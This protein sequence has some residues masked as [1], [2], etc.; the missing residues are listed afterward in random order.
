MKTDR[1]LLFESG[2]VTAECIVPS[3]KLPEGTVLSSSVGYPVIIP[4]QTHSLN[5]GIIDGHTKYYPDTDALISFRSGVAIG[6]RTADCV[7]ILLYFTS[8]AGVAAI[9]AGWRGTLGGIVGRVMDIL[10]EHGVS[11]EKVRAIFGPSIS[12]RKYEVDEELAGRFIEAGFPARVTRPD[13]PGGKPHLDLQ[14]INADRLLSRGVL[15][16]NIRLNPDC[17]YSALTPV[18]APKYHSHRRSGG[19]PARNFTVISLLP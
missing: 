2:N 16:D 13:D 7:P 9:H 10:E 4:D 6:V 14:G 11:P 1:N 8:P 12:G 17:T 18:G 5:V 19:D 15:P 3:E